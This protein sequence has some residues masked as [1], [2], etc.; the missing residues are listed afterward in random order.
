MRDGVDGFYSKCKGGLKRE[1]ERESVC[2][3]CCGCGCFEI[4]KEKW[5]LLRKKGNVMVFFFIYTK[6]LR[7]ISIWVRFFF[8]FSLCFSLSKYVFHQK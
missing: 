3:N 4:F 7:P 8:F 5:N 6:I 1:R 2:V